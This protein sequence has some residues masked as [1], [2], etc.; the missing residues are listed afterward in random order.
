MTGRGRW[1]VG[2]RA[3]GVY[4][5]AALGGRRRAAVGQSITVGVG[6]VHAAGCRP[7]CRVQTRELE[8]GR[9]GSVGRADC[10]DGD[11]VGATGDVDGA[12]AR[13]DRYGLGI[14]IQS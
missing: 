1:G 6:R 3:V 4:D 10:D 13:S 12:A 2:E 5:H 14:G 11:G 7:C 9:G 8:R